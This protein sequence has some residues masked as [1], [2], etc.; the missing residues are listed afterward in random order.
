MDDMRDGGVIFEEP[1]VAGTGRGAVG[2]GGH[3]GANGSR[4]KAVS[5]YTVVLLVGQIEIEGDLT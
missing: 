4:N 1:S 2:K 5:Q 3:R